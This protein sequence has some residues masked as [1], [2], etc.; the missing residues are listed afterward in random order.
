MSLRD[1]FRRSF[2]RPGLAAVASLLVLSGACAHR[3]PDLTVRGAYQF[4]DGRLMTVSPS[5]GP[6]LRYRDLE[7]GRS[8]RLYPAAAPRAYQT[9]PGW[10]SPSPVELEVRFHET[11][12]QVSGLE[13]QPK[14][15]ALQRAEKL[16]LR[17]E[18]IR[19]RSGNLTLSG[20]L[21]LPPGD[22][23][24]PAIVLVHG[25]ERD[26]ATLFYHEPYI[27]AAQGIAA[28]VYDKRGTGGSEG[29]FVMNFS[30]LADDAVAAV[31][32]VRRHP[33]V[34]PA[35]VGLCGSSQG[36]W[37]APLA[38]TRSDAV[39]FV[40]VRYGL[41][42]PPAQEDRDQAFNDLRA[43]G[44]GEDVLRQADELVAAVHGVLRT[45]FEGG[46]KELKQARRKFRDE[47]WL[48]DMQGEVSGDFARRP[49]WLLRTYGRFRLNRIELDWFYDSI[50]VLEKMDVP[51]FWMIAGKDEEAPPE[52]TLATL[53]RL[54]SAGRPVEIEV[55]P[56]ADHGIL[57]FEVK[58]G[59]RV[60]TRYAPGYFRS[61]VD[62]VRKQVGLQP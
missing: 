45:R 60:P 36:G 19:F 46:W 20:R 32:E 40:L 26:A 16:R 35:R 42:E 38:A 58:D 49:L 11:G 33:A 48:D 51:L 24:H 4:E 50:P 53:Q 56:D 31:E 10:A 29:K 17:E 30:K 25:S 7:S 21:V 12:P 59:E 14:D 13:W 52:A 47:P 43:A 9:G 44:H 37:I 34:D 62:W 39:R 57:E 22:G 27:F 18:P 3:S 55:F 8:Q 6:T 1:L 5:E 41:S 28:F 54:R 61:Q 2:R 23:P 15:G